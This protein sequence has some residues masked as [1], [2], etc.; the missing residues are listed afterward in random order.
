MSSNSDMG[1]NAN[2]ESYKDIREPLDDYDNDVRSRWMKHLFLVCEKT[3]TGS[4]VIPPELV[5][6]WKRQIETSYRDLSETEKQ[7]DLAEADRVIALLSRFQVN[8]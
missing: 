2:A 7:S 1:L 4:V 5:A 3:E 6:K 8:Q